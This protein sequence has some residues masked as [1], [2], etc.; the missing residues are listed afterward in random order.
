MQHSTLYQKFMAER[1]E[2]LRHKWLWFEREKARPGR[3][4][5]PEPVK[6]AGGSRFPGDSPHSMIGS[7]SPSS[8]GRVMPRCQ[9]TE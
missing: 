3:P 2:I 8:A 4:V 5:S 6:K 7:P 9:V 1:E